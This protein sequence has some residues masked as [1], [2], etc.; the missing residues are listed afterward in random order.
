MSAV[1]VAC[2]HGD[3]ACPCQDGAACN[4]EPVTLP[5]GSMSAPSPCRNPECAECRPV[6]PVCVQP[7]TDADRAEDGVVVMD[8]VCGPLDHHRRCLRGLD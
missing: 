1:T 6:C 2:A 4:Y 3:P 8:T 7:F 5:D